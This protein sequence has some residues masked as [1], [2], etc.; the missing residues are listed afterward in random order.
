MDV[1]A[2][3]LETALRRFDPPAYHIST[4][5]PKA[6]PGASDQGLNASLMMRLS[7]YVG[8]P[9][10]SRLLGAD[11]NHIVEHGYAHLLQVLDPATTIVTVHDL[12]PL[13]AW[14]GQ[15]PGMIYS[16]RPRLAEYSYR[17]LRKARYIVTISENTRKDVINYGRCCPEKVKVVY[18]GIDERFTQCRQAA[19][20][21]R[22]QF[23]LPSAETNLVLITGNEAYKN[24]RTCLAVLGQLVGRHGLRAKLVRVGKPC[25]EWDVLV[26]RSGLRDSVV[27]IGPI[28][29]ARMPDL[30]SSVDC[31]LF[32]SLYEGFG[33][34]PLEAMACGV[35]VVTSNVASLPE[36]VGDAALIRDPLDV[37]GLAA[38]V[39]ELLTFPGRRREMVERGLDR[40]RRFSW[41][42]HASAL[43]ELYETIA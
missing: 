21:L 11:V 7:R 42:A 40:A 9:W 20:E 39:A 30:Y 6:Y 41:R 4:F 22:K 38:D 15:I 8:Y 2:N 12:I 23:N 10:Q 32:P 19:S 14:R 31:L 17:F 16:H 28:P 29:H 18:Y 37:D 3:S 5:I 26:V 33:W 43:N 25:P 1:Y 36:V 13:L 27:E 34:P 24:H 35:P